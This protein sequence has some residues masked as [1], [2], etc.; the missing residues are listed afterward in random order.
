MS[1]RLAATMAP[2]DLHTMQQRPGRETRLGTAC[3]NGVH[4]AG[5]RVCAC[6]AASSSRPDSYGNTHHTN[7]SP[8]HFST[9]P[10]PATTYSDAP[11]HTTMPKISTTSAFLAPV[12]ALCP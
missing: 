8:T 6:I 12:R 10:P 3:D 2:G 1:S 5:Q 7:A 9:H 11:K 4:M